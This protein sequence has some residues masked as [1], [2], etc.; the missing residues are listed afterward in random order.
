MRR[1]EDAC[2]MN[3]TQSRQARSRTITR[4]VAAAAALG[5][6]L[7]AGHEA[8]AAGDDGWNFK[9]DIPAGMLAHYGAVVFG[10]PLVGTAGLVTGIGTGV[11]VGSGGPA[12]GWRPAAYVTGALNIV[13]SGLGFGLAGYGEDGV[14]IGV[15]LGLSHLAMGALNIGLAAADGASEG[16]GDTGLHIAPAFNLALDG[17]GGGEGTLGITG[18]F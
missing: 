10:G 11:E 8:H 12:T 5:A 4:V 13:W 3:Q 18:S 17:H 16:G 1:A 6:F 2:M 9:L 14:P 7:A 15:A